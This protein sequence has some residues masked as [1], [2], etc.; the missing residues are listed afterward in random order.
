MSYDV[1][2]ISE[3]VKNS[4]SFAQV[5][6]EIGKRG[7]GTQ[8]RIKL[9]CQKHSIDYRHFTGQAHCTPQPKVSFENGSKK[10]S[11]N[12]LKNRLFAAGV[13]KICQ[14]CGLSKWQGLS[15]P[16]ELHHRDGNRNN[17]NL[18]NLQILCPNCHAQTESY[19][20]RKTSRKEV[21]HETKNQ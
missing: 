15:A 21:S 3:A 14:R 18:S 10:V 12:T 7:S 19:C 6:R 2:Q 16:L 17:N 11:T 9:F 8:Q 20:K 13:P 1:L 5:M 4:L